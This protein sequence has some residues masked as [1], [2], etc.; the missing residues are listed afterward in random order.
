MPVRI[1]RREAL[2]GA[3]SA[4]LLHTG[5]SSNAID[6]GDASTVFR[7]GVASG[8][9]DHDSI[10]LWTRLS[11]QSAAISGEWQLSRSPDLRDPVR[12]GTFT[13]DAARDYT[14]KVIANGLTPGTVYYYGFTV[15]GQP[16]TVGRTRTLP[17]GS[18]ERLVLA[19]A[20]CS[21]FPFGYFNAYE[22]IANDDAIEYV[23]HLGDYIYEYGITGYGGPTGVR[24]GR[25]HDPEH[26]IV[27]LSDYRLRHAQYKADPQSQAMHAA[28]PLIAI[29]DDHESTNNPWMHG[30]ENHQPEQE[31]SWTKRRSESL[32]AYFEWMP[33]RD[34]ATAKQRAAYWRSFDFG[35]LARL[36]TLE[37]RHTGRA[38]QI[39]YAQHI[40]GLVTPGERDE[41]VSTVLQAKG[42]TMLSPDMEAFLKHAL[43]DSV[44]GRQRWRLIGN[45]IPIARTHVPNLDHPYFAHRR[46]DASDPVAAELQSLNKLGELDLPI[47]LD[48]W[49]GYPW[50]R[51]RFYDLCRDCDVTDLL[52]LTGDSHSFWANR[53]YDGNGRSMGVEIGTAGITSPGDFAAFGDDGAILMDDLLAQHNEEVVWTDGR[54]PGYVKLTL[55]RDSGTAEYLTVTDILS[56]RYDVRRLKQ[57]SIARDDHQLTLA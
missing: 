12:S 10:V 49:D 55:T 19:L 5:C 30:A 7:H 27:S 31:G 25:M 56:R 54:N 51:E 16:S 50:A 28:H 26:E 36:V 40:D 8:D 57:V 6:S 15:A 3:S 32:Q 13:T 38:Q 34:P 53:L 24:I 11:R 2:V 18:P 42:R 47:Y 37:T 21:N 41:F 35:D 22:A 33:V 17:Q 46:T 43:L 4:L 44:A 20:S 1:N 23:L 39:E 52:V 29:W 48:T 9:P 14:V 45:Q